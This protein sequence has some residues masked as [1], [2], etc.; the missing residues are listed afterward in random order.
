MTA[1]YVDD[2]YRGAHGI[3]RYAGEVLPR[4]RPEW[5][6]LGLDGNPHSPLDAFRRLPGVA[7]DSLV[8]SPGYGALLRAPRQV[9]TVHD[10]IHL[11]V[12]WPGRMKFA[13]YYGGPVRRTVRKAGLV[14]TVSETSARAIR[15]W[16]RDD[17]VRVVN[18]GNGCSAAFRPDGPVGTAAEPYVIFVG[19]T[20]LHKN[21]DVV[22]RALALAPDV[23]LRAVLPQHEIADAASRASAAGVADRV[24]W[25]HGV[26]DDRLAALYRG[27]S[28]TVMPS[29]LEGFGLPALESISS[30]VPVIY[31][32]G[33]EAVAE[34]VGDRG[35]SVETSGDAA[36]WAAAMTEAV[37][38]PRRVDPPVGEYD[39]DRT[40]A[41][42][43][44]ALEQVLA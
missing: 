28:A 1:L 19:N 37:R 30:G 38:A 42:I 22:L 23:R 14:L 33:C 3:G 29:T 4:L 6:P 34:I 9:L 39:W 31:W 10:L 21:L 12:P 41:V 15:E 27:A 7:H 13:A 18:A 16:L 8:Y 20:R 35:W 2:R 17:A 11:Q 43:S 32:Q 36:P 25:L 26:D 40:A 5:R 24:E 44:D